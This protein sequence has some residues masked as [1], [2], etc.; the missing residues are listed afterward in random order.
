ML[1]V[2]EN[3]KPDIVRMHAEGETPAVSRRVLITAPAPRD[4]RRRPNHTLT[5][6][7]KQDDQSRQA[8]RAKRRTL[9][10]E[11]HVHEAANQTLHRRRIRRRPRRRNGRD[12]ESA[13]QFA[14]RRGRRS[15]GRR[16][17]SRGGS[18]RKGLSR[19]V[20]DVRNG[21][22][23][24]AAQARRRDRGERRRSCAPRVP[25]H[26][27]S[28]AGHARARRASHRRH[29]PLFRRHGRQVRGNRR[30]GRSRLPE[31]RLA[32]AGRR[33]RPDRALELPADVHELE[34]GAGACR[35]LHG[36]AEARGADAA[37]DACALRS[38]CAKSAFP[39]AWSTS[40]PVTGRPPARGWPITRTSAR[41]P[42]PDRRLSAAGSCAAQPAISRRCSSNSA[43]RARTSC[44]TT[45]T[46]SLRSTAP[47]SP[48][49]TTRARLA[50][51]V[52][53]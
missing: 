30:S 9:G 3:A 27:P 46:L 31:L 17:R 11:L 7:V 20:R 53:G 28:A 1:L 49:S 40:S 6:F 34:D 19:V 13:R 15:S 22:G 32:R 52:R 35:R 36:R 37:V 33:R 2:W 44:S 48:S 26:R 29:L 42:S 14:D 39:Q 47:P 45:P 50:S 10:G 21:P 12:A 24:A 8:A 16:C 5:S 51:R 25:R 43:A 4:T 23:S 38:L 18:G 41:S